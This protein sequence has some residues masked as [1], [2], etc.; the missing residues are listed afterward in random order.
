MLLRGIKDSNF[1]FSSHTVFAIR[2]HY[3]LHPSM[4]VLHI[5]TL[6]ALRVSNLQRQHSLTDLSLISFC[7]YFP[8]ETTIRSEDCQAR[9]WLS[10]S[11]EIAV[12]QTCLPAQGSC[13]TGAKWADL[14]KVRLLND[15]KTVREE[16]KLQKLWMNG[17]WTLALCH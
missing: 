16:L 3:F 17:I 12:V 1:E 9:I 8:K 10:L 4:L 5:V 7:F 15:N 11:C 13:W 14:D 2:I 6:R